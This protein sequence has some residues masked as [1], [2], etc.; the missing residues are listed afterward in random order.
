VVDTVNLYTHPPIYRRM[1]EYA[2]LPVER[3][4]Q[5]NFL[6][7][8]DPTTLGHLIFWLVPRDGPITDGFPVVFPLT[9]E[10]RNDAPPFREWSLLHVQQDRWTGNLRLRRSLNG[11]QHGLSVWTAGL[12]RFPIGIRRIEGIRPAADL[13]GLR[14]SVAALEAE[15]TRLNELLSRYHDGVVNYY[16]DGTTT[17]YTSDALADHGDTAHAVVSDPDGTVTNLA[18]QWQ[19]SPP[20]DSNGEFSWTDIAGA[21]AQSRAINLADDV[22]HVLRCGASYDD[23]TGTGNQVFGGPL[24]PTT[25]IRTPGFLLIG[26]VD[27][28]ASV[29]AQWITDNMTPPRTARFFYADAAPATSLGHLLGGLFAV[30]GLT[31]SGS[32][33]LVILEMA[34]LTDL[35][36]AR[37]TPAGLA[38]SNV[39]SDLTQTEDHIVVD[40]ITY[41]AYVS[42]NTWTQAQFNGATLSLGRS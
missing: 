17:A 7:S 12:Q 23:P 13:T 2:G 21:N 19:R 22:G 29:T 41:N 28:V 30:S 31:F 36:T 33:S 10:W 42:S 37:W 18:Y 27:A 8:Q 9:E 34:E 38:Q 1:D 6:F 4:L 11:G 5:P 15:T 39:F 16:K 26:A 35:T 3:P 20:A 32:L 24:G 14:N 25:G 40:G